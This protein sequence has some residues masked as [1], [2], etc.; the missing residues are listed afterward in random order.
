MEELRDVNL[1]YSLS[2]NNK[3]KK[4]NNTIA[5]PSNMDV[6]FNN[7]IKSMLIFLCWMEVIEKLNLLALHAIIDLQV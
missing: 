4:K 7:S 5:M 1:F 3:V 6:T 2:L